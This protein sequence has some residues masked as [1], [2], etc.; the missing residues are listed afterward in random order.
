MIILN[1]NSNLKIYNGI[2]KPNGMGKPIPYIFLS[3]I[4]YDDLLLVVGM[5]FLQ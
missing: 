3:L 2:I 1:C 5:F 4:V